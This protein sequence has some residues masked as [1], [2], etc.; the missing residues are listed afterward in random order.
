[1]SYLCQT[2]TKYLGSVVCVNL[3]ILTGRSPNFSL[4]TRQNNVDKLLAYF[5]IN[6]PKGGKVIEIEYC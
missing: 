6:A 1:M 3:H 4:G 2:N 5:N